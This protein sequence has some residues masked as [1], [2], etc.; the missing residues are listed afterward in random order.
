[1]SWLESA[2]GPALSSVRCALLSRSA[3]DA[4]ESVVV[5]DKV[6]VEDIVARTYGDVG[7]LLDGRLEER[8]TLK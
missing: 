7:E 5:E 2:D 4:E 3:E 8:R 6:G 1:M